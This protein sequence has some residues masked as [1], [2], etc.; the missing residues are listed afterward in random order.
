N[1]GLLRLRG[2]SGRQ[3][4]ATLLLAIGLGGLVGGV[5][6]AVL[7]TALP[8]FIY[9]G[10]IPPL[11]LVPKIQDPLYLA[12]FLLV[13]LSIALLSG[14]NFVAA[15]SRMAPL[16]GARRVDEAGMQTQGV[17]FG[18]FEFIALMLGGAKF[19]FWLSDWSL[20]YVSSAAW[21]TD[22]DR[23]LDFIAFPLFIYGLGAFIP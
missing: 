4:A 5:L 17:H 10:G 9:F 3:I 7:G 18:V 6:G 15:A 13:G 21:I 1:L 8:L 23:A 16:E 22:L 19:I 14:R 20:T 11:E 2:V 12:V